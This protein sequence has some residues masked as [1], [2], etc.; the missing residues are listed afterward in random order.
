[1]LVETCVSTIGSWSVAQTNNDNKN[2][3]TIHDWIT[4]IEISPPDDARKPTHSNACFRSVCC[5]RRAVVNKVLILKLEWRKIKKKLFFFLFL[6]FLFS[7]HR[8]LKWISKR[9]TNYK[10]T[11]YSSQKS[12]SMKR[13]FQRT[14]TVSTKI[15][16]RIIAVLIH[17]RDLIH[18]VSFW[19][20]PQLLV[21]RSLRVCIVMHTKRRILMIY[22][23]F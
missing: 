7:S 15:S 4:Y 9:C 2:N 13:N 12:S 11:K 1:M 19:N 5:C 8:G 16:S 18:S 6:L 20:S 21:L 22:L 10:F 3:M 17:V 23:K 14:K